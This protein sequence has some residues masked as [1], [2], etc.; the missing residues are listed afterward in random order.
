MTGERCRDHHRD[1]L[2]PDHE[3][4]VVDPV[5][6]DAGDEAEDRADEA[7]EGEQ[8][9]RERRVRQLDHEPREGDVLHP[10]AADRDHLAR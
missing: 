8:A 4:A 2:G 5:G 3:L 6:D 1:R 9:D 7:A 10:G